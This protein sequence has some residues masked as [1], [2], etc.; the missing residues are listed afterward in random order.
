[1]AHNS[2]IDPESIHQQEVMPGFRSWLDLPRMCFLISSL[3]LI[4]LRRVEKGERF[5]FDMPYINL[6]ALAVDK[7]QS[8]FYRIG[9]DANFA[10]PD[11]SSAPRNEAYHAL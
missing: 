7:G 10:C 3:L 6:A 8:G 4:S 11:V 5:Y 9:R 2:G 1:M